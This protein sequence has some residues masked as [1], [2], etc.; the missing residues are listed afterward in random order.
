MILSSTE[1]VSQFSRKIFY[2]TNWSQCFAQLNE[3]VLIPPKTIVAHSLLTISRFRAQ[4]I[5]QP[6]NFFVIDDQ[7][8]RCLMLIIKIMKM[9]MMEISNT[10][11]HLYKTNDRKSL[12]SQNRKMKNIKE[13]YCYWLAC[14]ELQI[15]VCIAAW[16]CYVLDQFLKE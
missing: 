10:T 13:M 3:L 12:Y 5:I 6:I 8:L 15:S 16:W 7:F 11:F 1:R 9:K 4:P 14:F 2:L